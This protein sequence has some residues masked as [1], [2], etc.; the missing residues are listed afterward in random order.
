[1][2]FNNEADD[3]NA[4]QLS[5]YLARKRPFIIS[6]ISPT[7]GQISF[8][9]VTLPKNW[10]PNTSYPLY[11]Q[12]HGLWSVASNTIE[13]MT[14]PYLNAASTSFAFEDGY[15]LSPW[16]RGNMWYIGISETDIWECIAALGEHVSIDPTRKYLCGHSMGGYGT[17][18]IALNSSNTW[19]AI[20]LHAAAIWYNTSEIGSTAANKLKNVPVYFVCGTSDDLLSANQYLFQMLRQ[21]GNQNLSFVTF[22]GGHDYRQVDVEDMYLW[23]HKFVNNNYTHTPEVKANS[24]LFRLSAFPNPFNTKTLIKYS[25]PKSSKVKLEI[26]NNQGCYIE[27]ISDLQ[28]VAGDYQ[29][30]WTPEN[31][32]DGVYYC[33]LTTEYSKSMNIIVYRK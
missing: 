8:S 19:A 4:K 9:W 29:I 25:L 11:V 31:L 10:N 2:A 33:C 1:L 27:I 32:P 20:G 7:D 28:Q 5:T 24:S 26:Y 30:Y 17:W 15:V 6:W 12:L 13:Y 18:H 22:A 21:V 23:M 16:G 3:A 14:Y